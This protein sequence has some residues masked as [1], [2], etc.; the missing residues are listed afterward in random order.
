MLPFPSSKLDR[1]AWFRLAFEAIHTQ[2]RGLRRFTSTV[3]AGMRTDLTCG[4]KPVI[5]VHNPRAGGR[6]LGDYLGVGRKKSHAYPREKL[7]ERTWLDCFVV[8]PV[9]HPLDR[10]F[11]GYF[12]NVKTEKENALVRKY[13]WGVKELSPI[14]YLALIQRETRH[15]GPQ[16]QWTDYPSAIKPRADLVLRL[17][18]VDS[19]EDRI[20]DAGIDAHGRTLPHHG[21]T[22]NRTGHQAD[23]L[24]LAP[25]EMD[26]LR[27]AI[28]DYF[29]GDYEAFGYAR[30]T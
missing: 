15:T 5:F 20:R 14:E 21:K 3:G 28:E 11:S 2:Q 9:R 24:G 16:L 8:C 25:G 13:G 7:A 4:G 6:S 22:R 23:L 29:A 26:E 12:G 27:A 10:F 18:D 17:E 19:W 1:P 30:Q